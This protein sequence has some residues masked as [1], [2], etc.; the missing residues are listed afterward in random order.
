M[1]G[2]NN[3]MVDNINQEIA[4]FIKQ[5]DKLNDLIT[6]AIDDENENKVKMFKEQLDALEAKKKAKEDKLEEV[7]LKGKCYNY[8]YLC[9]KD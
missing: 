4:N 2:S 5:I 3:S 8:K 6:Q 1:E 9:T 7:L